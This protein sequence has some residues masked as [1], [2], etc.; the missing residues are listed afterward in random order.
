MRF[1]F[2][3]TLS[4]R[5]V[6]A[7][8][9]LIVTFA[10]V[11]AVTVFNIGLVGDE[12][13]ILGEGYSELWLSSKELSE[14]QSDVNDYVK[15]DLAGEPTATRAKGQ[16]NKLRRARMNKV[17][18]IEEILGRLGDLPTYHDEKLS[19][20][21]TRVQAIKTDLD[22]LAPLYDQLMVNPPLDKNGPPSEEQAK[23]LA[24]VKK[25][26]A[27]LSAK[28]NRLLDKQHGDFK[29]LINRI[30]RTE[31][32]VRTYSVIFGLTAV[33]LGFLMTAWAVFTLRPLRRL[34]DAAQ[35]IAQGDYGSRIDEKGPTEVADLAR[36]FNVMGRAVEER[37]REL[38]RSERLVAVGKMAAMITHEVRNPLSSIGLNTE[39]LTEELEA[40]P[41][42]RAV[43]AQALCKAINAEVDR[44]TGITEGYL[45]FARLPK[46]KLQAESVERI[47]RNLADFARG[48]LSTRGVQLEL[49]IEADLPPAQIDEGQLR[50][51]LL[52]LVRNAA[53]SIE[54]SGS[55]SGTVTIAA[56]RA[57][58]AVEVEVKD[59]GLGIAEDAQSKLF[60]PFFS[61]KQGGTGLGLALTDQIVREHGGS[62]RV[63]SKPGEGARFIL[64]LPAAS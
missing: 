53:E 37:E 41:P 42:E 13:R 47:I 22:T 24:Q 36:E 12:I 21:A 61:T 33:F 39:L 54:E 51:S 60:D 57:G 43:E 64:T 63:D 58:A 62:I 56:R 6:L 30:D 49:A 38:V 25:I 2:L 40:L 17:T 59:D 27:G 31:N 45:Q 8:A 5:I 10:G 35:R 23:L 20:T 32:A 50:Q 1:P 28:V 18:R 16:L 11:S 15:S 48:E 34:R 9:V 44:L 52:N 14:K 19:E 55:G 26:E 29:K 46:P 4:S 7:F 3:R